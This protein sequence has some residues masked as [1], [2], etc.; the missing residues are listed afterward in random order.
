MIIFED[1]GID[2]TRFG[3]KLSIDGK[4]IAKPELPKKE[5]E[6]KHPNAPILH[7]K[8]NGQKIISYSSKL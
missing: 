3:V 4:V 2:G 5:A 1:N 8:K 7:F 6:E